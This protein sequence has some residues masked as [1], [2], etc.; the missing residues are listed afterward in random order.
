M[1]NINFNS[2]K[3]N[4]YSVDELF[5]LCQTG[6]VTLE[7]LKEYGLNEPLFLELYK[8]I[9]DFREIKELDDWNSV[10][11][12]GIE[13]IEFFI[14]KNNLS[15]GELYQLAHRRISFLKELS[16]LEDEIKKIMRWLES[17]ELYFTIDSLRE[18]ENNLKNILPLSNPQ[19]KKRIERDLNDL[20]RLLCSLKE[21]FCIL[22]PEYKRMI[23]PAPNRQERE[24]FN[25]MPSYTSLNQESYSVRNKPSYMPRRIFDS[26]NLNIFK[27]KETV[28][29]SAVFAPAEIAKGDDMF[30]Q[31]YIYK[32][33][34]TDDVIIDSR[35]SDENATQRSYKPLNLPIKTGDKISVRLDMHGLSVEGNNTKSVIW[36][37]K[38]TKCS[39]FVHVPINYGKI[40]VKGD[41]Y[42]SV[43]GMELGQMSFFSTI[44]RRTDLF[45]SALVEAKIYEKV[46]ISYSHKDDHIAKVIAEAYKALGTVKYFYDRHTLS[47]GDF[48]EKEI[49]DFIDQSDLFILCWSKNAETSEW[50]T[51]ERVRAYYRAVDSPPQLK[52][53]P[54]NICPQAAPPSDLAGIIHF[55]DYDK[56]IDLSQNQDEIEG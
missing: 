38:Y 30:V 45:H 51:K 5:E 9:N 31:V 47:P 28:G 15:E 13:K 3:I 24:D 7:E 27:K 19:E 29:N 1:M 43:N 17:R 48:F 12:S 41:V 52:I 21:I 50:V 16:K 53:Y 46:F 8:R 14:S 55:E 44:E 40:K 25:Y 6:V 37:N 4:S 10:K 23:C 18:L 32:D 35:T 2:R 42:L 56:L 11:D 26:F 36:Q 34:E 20:E 22:K 39:F 54:I 33:E 49:F